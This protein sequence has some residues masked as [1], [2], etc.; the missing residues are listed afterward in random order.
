M[1]IACDRCHSKYSVADEK[2]RGKTVRIRCRECQATIV[3]KAGATTPLPT[4]AARAPVA[5]L[6]ESKVPTKV[7]NG[8]APAAVVKRGGARVNRD[9][10][11]EARPQEASTPAPAPAVERERERPILTP[12]SSATAQRNETSVLFTLAGLTRKPLV[13]K[14]PEVTANSGLIDLNGMRVVPGAAR[15]GSMIQ[16]VFG[17]APPLGAVTME[18]DQAPAPGPTHRRKLFAGIGAAT[19]FAIIAIGFGMSGSETKPAAA[20]AAVTAPVVVPPPAPPP[21]E[22]VAA[23]AVA[24]AAPAATTAASSARSGKAGKGKKGGWTVKAA[25]PAKAT[26]TTRAAPAK[27]GG[28]DACGC[29]GELMCLMRCSK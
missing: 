15:P 20:A 6:Y 29:N 7:G 25:N 27:R 2:V 4:P 17:S 3:V 28:G 9:Y 26:K 24:D 14:P 16:P 11:A 5:A 13:S 22:A 10:V 23:V 12:S 1:M 19:L 8:P 21:V 18:V